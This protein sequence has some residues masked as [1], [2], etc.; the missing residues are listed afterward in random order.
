MQA[1]VAGFCAQIFPVEPQRSCLLH[2]VV[3][4]FGQRAGEGFNHHLRQRCSGDIVRLR[5]FTPGFDADLF[6]NAGWFG[7]VGAE[8][9]QGGGI[10][11]P[12][13]HAPAQFALQTL[14]QA[15]RN[16][17]VAVIV[18]NGAKQPAGGG[19]FFFKRRHFS[20]GL[21]FLCRARFYAISAFCQ[22]GWR[23]KIMFIHIDK[24]QS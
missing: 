2:D 20:D 10:V 18:D 5:A 16:A 14:C 19:E 23:E 3:Y 21:K 8:A 13:T 24:I 7:Q 15:P 11:Y 22:A 17:D 6:I 1:F 12:Q 9:A 4:R